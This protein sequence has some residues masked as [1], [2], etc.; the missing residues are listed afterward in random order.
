MMD[1]V[2]A[3]LRWSD[4]APECR[5]Y[6]ETM[7]VELVETLL[8]G[9]TW[10][11]H[12]EL[13]YYYLES[14]VDQ[15]LVQEFG[16]WI[17]GWRSGENGGP[18]LTPLDP[19]DPPEEQIATV[20]KAIAE[21]RDFL[22]DVDAIFTELPSPANSSLAKDV[23]KA[24]ARLTPMVLHRTDAQ[25]AWYST[26]TL[27]LN[28]FLESHGYGD[29]LSR[30]A[31]SQTFSG[32]FR[33]WVKPSDEKIRDVSRSVGGA[34]SKTPRLS[35][36]DALEHWLAVRESPQDQ[37]AHSAPDIKPLRL[38]G[39]LAYINNREKDSR[40][41]DALEACRK[42]ADGQELLTLETLQ[43]WQKILL[44]LEQVEARTTD[45]FAKGGRER[46]GVEHLSKFSVLL[47]EAN[48]TSLSPQWRAAMLYLDICFFH[49]FRDGNARLARL[50]LDAVLWRAGFG[51]NYVEPIFVTAKAAED[52]CGG[53]CLCITVG[54][55]MGAHR[56]NRLSITD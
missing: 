47:A 10:A 44:G 18:V 49:P 51:L 2:T 3:R 11:D 29:R 5:Q 1:F 23:E 27:V 15:V 35:D 42:W 38:D 46:Y 40:M 8:R 30:K 52:T 32:Q 14:C 43:Q 12:N 53:T 48:D 13:S 50:A 7:A 36:E 28:W 41:L 22:T 55:L 33:S 17:S 4:V 56:P 24:A 54:G 31:I 26:C 6:D 20:M 16:V 37:W 19:Y 45:A 39:H 21:W 9:Q 34:V 25:D